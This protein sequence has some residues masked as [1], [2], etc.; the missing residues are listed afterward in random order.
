MLLAVHQAPIRP[1]DFGFTPLAF[2]RSV[3]VT[4]IG[5]RCRLRMGTAGL[6]PAPDRGAFR[7]PP[8][9]L[10]HTDAVLWQG[11]GKVL[12]AWD[13]EREEKRIQR[14]A[15]CAAHARAAP[16]RMAPVRPMPPAGLVSLLHRVGTGQMA[17]RRAEGGAALTPNATAAPPQGW[18]ACRLKSC[19]TLSA[20]TGSGI[21]P[22][23]SI[24]CA[25]GPAVLSMST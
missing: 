11:A 15:P 9:R 25:M 10:F 7:T 14:H 3:R 16:P 20:A 13:A 4:G 19:L 23:P 6:G 5:Q 1:L 17:R 24:A 18:P 2:A 8:V 12:T 22:A 21:P